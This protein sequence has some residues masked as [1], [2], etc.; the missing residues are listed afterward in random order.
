M[1]KV[2]DIRHIHHVNVALV[3]SP[4]FS[5]P[6]P[7][8]LNIDLIPQSIHDAMR[9]AWDP[10]HF[11]PRLISID[12]V[13]DVFVTAEGLVF[14]SDYQ[15]IS[16]TVTQHSLS[17]QENALT[18]VKNFAPI[19]AIDTSC[20]LM[21][22]RGDNNYGHWLVEVLPKL[23]LARSQCH[24]SGLA[25]PSVKGPMQAV[26]S[27]SL[28]LAD[29]IGTTPRFELESNNVCLFK[30]LILVSGAT[31]HGSYM[32]PLVISETDKLTAGI[33]GWSNS[34]RLFVSRR[35]QRRN[36]VNED[37]VER[38]L[39][40]K[41]F[42]VIHPGEMNFLD[43]I[44]AF[45]SA[46][47][48]VGVMGAGMTNIIFANSGAKVINL[49]PA[50]MPDTFFYFLSILKGHDYMELRGLNLSDTISWDEPFSIDA[51]DIIAEA[52]GR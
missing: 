51:D 45:K 32:S 17:E 44:K 16:Q 47:L 11:A 19:A 29:K 7:K 28:A 6:H 41:G 8:I 26:I 46:E 21:R 24:V 4:Q 36:L 49:S 14:T 42:F 48:I 35:G 40:S 30:E 25:I 20:V 9:G 23:A 33:E 27:D 10:E 12:K 31:E 52:L 43:Q 22:K 5:A 3:E 15:I 2:T 13:F 50:T 37:L 34:Q 38:E 1:V 39:A 18:L